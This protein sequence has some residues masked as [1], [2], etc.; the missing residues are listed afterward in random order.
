M[1]EQT[2]DVWINSP[3]GGLRIH[4]E[5][6]EPELWQIHGI[7][8]LY[9]SS[10]V[11]DVA[12]SSCIYSEF[13]MSIRQQLEAYFIDS[14]AEFELPLSLKGTPFQQR[15]WKYLQSIPV[16]E[17]RTYGWLAKQLH[18]SAQAVG[19]ACRSN[20]VPIVVPCHRVVGAKGAGGFAGKMSGEPMQVKHWLLLHEGVQADFLAK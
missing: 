16:G 18:S 20:P 1:A 8:F 7:D 5:C 17:V 14:S 12:K 11:D 10:S 4:S 2:H 19:N 13:E 9:Q 15:V 6:T 3:I